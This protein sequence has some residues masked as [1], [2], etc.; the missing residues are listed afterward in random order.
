[1]KKPAGASLWT[2][3][4]PSSPNPNSY[5]E[6]LTPPQ[7]VSVFRDRVFKEEIKLKWGH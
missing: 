3:F 6:V 4:C 1:M 7:N 2:E 5:I